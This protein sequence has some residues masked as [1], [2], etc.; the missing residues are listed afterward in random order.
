MQMYFTS[1]LSIFKRQEIKAQPATTNSSTMDKLFINICRKWNNV[2][3]VSDTIVVIAYLIGIVFLQYGIKCR[4]NITKQK[5]EAI[6]CSFSVVCIRHDK[7]SHDQMLE[8]SLFSFYSSNAPLCTHC[9]YIFGSD[10]NNTANHFMLN[11]KFNMKYVALHYF[12]EFVD[13]SE[14]HMITCRPAIPPLARPHASSG[15]A[16]CA[17]TATTRPSWGWQYAE[18]KNR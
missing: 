12:T 3:L 17:R 1:R 14:F 10:I 2:Q 11:M 15:P 6:P 16:A 7:P 8:I 4:V 9:I 5:N 13:S 18:V